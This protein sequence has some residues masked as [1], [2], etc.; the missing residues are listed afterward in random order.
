MRRVKRSVLDEGELQL[1]RNQMDNK[2]KGVSSSV[3]V[4]K[5]AIL[6]ADMA[7]YTSFAEKMPLYDVIDLLNRYFSLMGG[8][9]QQHRGWI[10]DYAGDSLLAV[11]GLND[12]RQAC[13]QAVGAGIGMLEALKNFNTYVAALYGRQFDIRVGIHF[14]EVIVGKIGIYPMQKLAVVGDAVN[15]ASRIE[16]ANKTLGTHLLISGQVYEQV[17]KNVI[18]N[19]SFEMELRGK[20]GLYK[21]VNIASY[22]MPSNMAED[23]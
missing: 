12:H 14:G 19:Q 20:S 10:S 16:E 4:K 6:F 8:V 22:L 9:V 15:M 17:S 3:G 23:I 21:L 11:F 7:D 13:I 1:V 2:V 5:L 18:I